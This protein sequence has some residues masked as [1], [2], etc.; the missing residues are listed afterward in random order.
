[1]RWIVPTSDRRRVDAV[2]AG[3]AV[4][5]QAQQGGWGVPT[6][7]LDVAFGVEEAVGE[8]VDGVEGQHRVPLV[9]VV[10]VDERAHGPR[11]R[12]ARGVGGPAAG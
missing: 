12:C 10:G 4:A 8:Q 6:G 9:V 1:V 5:V 3:G 7:L 2:G 11:P